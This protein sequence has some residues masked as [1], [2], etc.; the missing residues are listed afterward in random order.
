MVKCRKC[1][2]H[3]NLIINK[4]KKSGHEKKKYL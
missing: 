2:T 3:E 4:F 1:D